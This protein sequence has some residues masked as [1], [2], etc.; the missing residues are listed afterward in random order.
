MIDIKIFRDQ[1][2]LIRDSE[3][4]RF[5]D[6]QS[7]DK[8]IELD[9]KWRLL[10]QKVNELR[11]ER[12]QISRQIGP[13]KKKGEDIGPLKKRVTQIKNEITD[14]EHQSNNSLTERDRIRYMIGNILL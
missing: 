1:P 14:I 7:V 4:K 11:K 6:P 9:E 10:L 12:N 2:Q 3:K 8:V 13:M 5:K